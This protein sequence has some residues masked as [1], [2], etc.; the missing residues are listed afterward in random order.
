MRAIWISGA[1][2]QASLTERRWH[3]ADSYKLINQY[4]TLLTSR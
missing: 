2:P 3:Q 1:M 4:Q